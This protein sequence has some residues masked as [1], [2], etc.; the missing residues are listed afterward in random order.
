MIKYI[1][2]GIASIAAGGIHTLLVA[3]DHAD[4]WPEAL[5][6][7]LFGI[8]Q[9]IWG[10]LYIHKPNKNKVS[11]GLLMSG[12]MLSLAILTRLFTA[13]FLEG[14]EDMSINWAI[15]ILLE[16]VIIG[17]FIGYAKKKQLKQILY[18]IVEAFVLGALLYGGSL[19]VAAALP[20]LSGHGHDESST[21]QGGMLDTHDDSEEPANHID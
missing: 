20:E 5:F 3:L 1:L 9:I 18:L 6:F 21:T 11:I 16:L 13:P 8:A 10:I 17:S 14:P 15:T 4:L 12:S 7:L 2:P 19:A